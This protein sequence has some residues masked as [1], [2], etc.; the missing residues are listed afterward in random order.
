M[1]ELLNNFV[2]N[3]TSYLSS[4]KLDAGTSILIGFLLTA[5]SVVLTQAKKI[6]DFLLYDVFY[7]LFTRSVSIPSSHE[8]FPAFEAWVSDNMGNILW[9]RGGPRAMSIGRDTDISSFSGSSLT[10]GKDSPVYIKVKGLPLLRFFKEVAPLEKSAA[11]YDRQQSAEITV[12]VLS[13]NT[14][15]LV[16]VVAHIA[17]DYSLLS[18]RDYIQNDG[19][20]ATVPSVRRS[21]S[22]VIMDKVVLSRVQTNIEDFLRPETRKMY[23]EWGVPYRKTILLHSDPGTGKTSLVTALKTHYKMTLYT[24]SLSSI[25]TDS[26][27]FSL[28]RQ[29]STNSK[30]HLSMVLLEDVDCAGLPVGQR[31]VEPG[32]DE[33]QE[34]VSSKGITLSGM[35]N[36]L[37]GVYGLKNCIVFMTTNHLEKLDPAVVRDGRVD[38]SIRLEAF[39]PDLQQ[40]MINKFL[41]NSGITVPGCAPSIMPATLQ[42]RCLEAIHS[43]DMSLVE[44]WR[45]KSE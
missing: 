35:L 27:L 3:S 22:S 19:W 9:P 11:G 15:D 21:L 32:E 24:L 40:E 39:G 28:C 45:V 33:V 1:L 20:F 43:N 26:D 2:Q 7:P 36:A 5:V 25:K 42:G 31:A 18:E 29:I 14:K 34:G 44:H 38:L 4:L 13:R 6:R 16:R 12:R 17:K 23:E 41:P 30:H 37:D 10:L 8:T